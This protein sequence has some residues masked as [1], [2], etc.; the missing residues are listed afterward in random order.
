V[1]KISKAQRIQNI[2]LFLGNKTMKFSELCKAYMKH[3]NISRRTAERYISYAISDK[4]I[5]KT[6]DGYQLN[7]APKTN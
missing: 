6:N 7:T 4:I 1:V 3:N 5:T 2:S